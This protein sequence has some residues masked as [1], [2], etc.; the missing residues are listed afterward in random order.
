[1]RTVSID[2][3]WRIAA[4]GLLLAVTTVV[5]QQQALPAGGQQPPPGGRQGGPPGPGRQGGTGFPRVPS[6]PFP[7]APQ[8]FE[9]LGPKIRVV[10]LVRDLVNP[11]SIAFLPGGDMLITE[12][13]GR[14]RIVRNGTLDPQPIAGVPQVWAIG[15]GGLLEVL[16]HPRFT[17]NQFVYLTYSK[18]CDAGATTALA[19]GRFDG[20]AL[21]DLRD[22]FVADNCNTG[23]PHFGSKLAFGRDGMLYMTIGERGD[24]NR[25]QNTA[26]HGG[27][28][29]RLKEDGTVPPDNPFIGKEGYKPEIFT[30]G[31]R[32]PQGLAF[33]P[34]TGV[35]WENE[36]GPQGGDELNIIERGK[37]YG[38]PVVT[39]GREYTG[40][41]ITNQPWREGMEQ[42]V[43]Q[44]SPSIGISGL[45]IY[46]GERLPAW[47]GNFFVGGLSGQHIQRVVFNDRGVFGRETLIGAMRQRI[48]DVR[49]GP[50]GLLY[51]A[52]DAS[53]GGILRIEPAQ[54][55][56]NT[57]GGQ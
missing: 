55:S 9:T 19:R 11:W 48:R 35:L 13:P 22:L 16:P 56:T 46:N 50:D 52:A 23:N 5:A 2:H 10:P 8:E 4:T 20:K 17:E 40:E 28:I 27:K 42:P 12:K 3:R 54:T 36:H 6:L 37:N 53:A 39:F 24:R 51:V 1:M 33:H 7:D 31:H 44:W 14:L 21:A 15:Q 26:I 38:W 45:V 25:A 47:K 29:L 43:L 32:N 30:Y 49:Q 18:P 41:I 34:D 57:A